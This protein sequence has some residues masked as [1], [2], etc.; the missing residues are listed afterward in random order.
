[1]SRERLPR[2]RVVKGKTDQDKMEML[3]NDVKRR[4]ERE[5]EKERE[6]CQ[7]KRGI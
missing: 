6:G 2:A 7:G 4:R 1:M 3:E 5:R